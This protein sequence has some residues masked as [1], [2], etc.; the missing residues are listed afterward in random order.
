MNALT[1][2]AAAVRALA[3]LLL[4]TLGFW[5]LWPSVA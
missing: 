4:S 5:L 3:G 2:L 1:E